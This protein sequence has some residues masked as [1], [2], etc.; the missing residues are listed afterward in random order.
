MLMSIGF[1]VAYTAGALLGTIA[2]V[3]LAA[4][5]QGFELGGLLAWH[6]FFGLAYLQ[7]MFMAY[8]GFSYSLLTTVFLRPQSLLA[9][10]MDA[11]AEGA[12]AAEMLERRL[13]LMELGKLIRRQKNVILCL[14]RGQRLGRIS[15]QYVRLARIPWTG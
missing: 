15:R 12:G 6:T 1:A 8:R 13:S 10:V 4:E 5:P 3:H 9:E 2:Y 14:P 7:V 11:F